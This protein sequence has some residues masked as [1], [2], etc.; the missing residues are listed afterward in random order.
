MS[1][2]RRQK[3]VQPPPD[4]AHVPSRA[5]GGRKAGLAV[6]AGHAASK[7]EIAGTGGLRCGC[8]GAS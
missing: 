5:P 4:S 1:A 3:K 2:R 8:V 7:L 6:L